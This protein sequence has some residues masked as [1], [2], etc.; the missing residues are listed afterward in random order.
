M[1]S[2]YKHGFIYLIDSIDK[3]Y[4]FK[5]DTKAKIHLNDNN[6]RILGISC[7]EVECWMNRQ[8][9]KD[10]KLTIFGGTDSFSNVSEIYFNLCSVLK[11]CS[12]WCQ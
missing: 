1:E 4:N 12:I 9:E 5:I 3:L 6:I 11:D 2:S 8:N 10:R 7:A